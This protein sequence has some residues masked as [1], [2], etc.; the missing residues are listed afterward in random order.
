MAQAP[1][2]DLKSRSDQWKA[3]AVANDTEAKALEDK[4]K[5]KRKAA[6]DARAYAAEYNAAILKLQTP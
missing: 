4:A 2:A 6:K 3:S 5:D 1:I